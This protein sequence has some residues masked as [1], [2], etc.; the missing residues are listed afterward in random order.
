MT[1]SQV[2]WICPTC[3]R[4]YL[5]KHDGTLRKHWARDGMGRGL[6]FSDPCA[7]SGQKP[8]RRQY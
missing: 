2:R 6:P 5:L 7:G 1:V 8:A 3:K 4:A